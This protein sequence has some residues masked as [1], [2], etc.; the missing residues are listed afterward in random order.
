MFVSVFFLTLLR[1]LFLE[2]VAEPLGHAMKVQSKDMVK[3][4]DQAW[5]GL[6]TV[7]LRQCPCTSLENAARFLRLLN[8]LF[9]NLLYGGMVLGV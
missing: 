2:L 1:S 6:P 3:F 8:Y 7:L 4:N 9:R 5:Q